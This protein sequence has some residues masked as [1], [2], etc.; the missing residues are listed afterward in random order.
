MNLG[1]F[2]VHPVADLFPLLEGEEFTKLVEDIRENGLLDPITLSH[3]GTH[4]IDG[5]N[6]WRACQE[7]LVDPNYTRLGSHYTEPLIIDYIISKNLNRRHLDAGQRAM[8]GL[9]LMEHYEKE[10]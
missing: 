10:A 2:A 7:A 5:R 6:R 1:K 4:L 8:I 9:D 3:D